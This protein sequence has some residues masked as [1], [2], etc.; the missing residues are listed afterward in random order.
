MALKLSLDI[1]SGQFVAHQGSVAALPPLR[2]GKLDVELRLVVP[3]PDAVPGLATFTAADLTGYLG[4]RMGIWSDSTGTLDDSSDYLLALTP[5]DAFTYNTD[6][7]D[8]PYFT[9][10]LDLYTQ[11]LADEMGSEKVLMAYFAI[12]LVRADLTIEPVFD[13]RGAPSCTVYSA[14]DDASG[15]LPTAALPGYRPIILPVYF[16]SADG[17]RHYVLTENE[18]EDGLIFTQYTP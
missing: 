6:D 14:T 18:T 17:E 7:V 12:G 11:E 1:N 15:T 5:H 9:G 10:T 2:Q 16:Q 8:D 13:H 3:N 4:V